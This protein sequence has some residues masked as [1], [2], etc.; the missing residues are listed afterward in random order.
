[1]KEV[2]GDPDVVINYHVSKLLSLPTQSKPQSLKDLYHKINTHVRGLA[3]LGI[4]AEQD[5]VFLGPTVMSKMSDSLRKDIIKSKIKDITGL[6]DELKE[7]VELESSS[8]QV[9]DAFSLETKPEMKPNPDLVPGI[10][11]MIPN[12][13]PTQQ[14]S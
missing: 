9:K 10:R 13:L 14:K 12:L 6:H 5:S 7:E 2:Y 8:Q 11:T 4:D 3:A 1:M